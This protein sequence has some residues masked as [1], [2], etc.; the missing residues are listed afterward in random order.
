MNEPIE[1]TREKLYRAAIACAHVIT[2]DRITLRRDASKPGNAL[3]QL[4]D[5]L[6]AAVPAQGQCPEGWTLVRRA[7]DLLIAEHK[8]GAGM[9]PQVADKHR[10]DIDAIRTVLTSVDFY[11]SRIK[12]QCAAPAAPV[13]AASQDKMHKW[14]KWISMNPP[15][16]PD[17]ACAQCVPHSDIIAPGFVCVYHDALALDAARANQEKAK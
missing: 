7:L 15:A 16:L 6:L 1:T 9:F 2:K 3:A 12:L 11:E 17:H 4:A 5:R 13:V 8:Y 10:E 14:A